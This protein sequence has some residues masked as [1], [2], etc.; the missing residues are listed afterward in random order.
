MQFK[1]VR[2]MA[3]LW[4]IEPTEI[5]FDSAYLKLFSFKI[6]KLIPLTWQVSEIC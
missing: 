3:Y 2:P 6:E 5:I 4:Q 1:L